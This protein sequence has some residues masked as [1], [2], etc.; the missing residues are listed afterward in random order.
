MVNQK[1]AGPRRFLAIESSSPRLSLAIGD[2]ERVLARWQSRAAWRHSEQLVEAID[3]LAARRRW[4]L[5]SF[6]GVAV[7]VGPGSFTGIRIGVTAA[8]AF[9]QYLSIP[10]LGFSSL[11]VLAAGAKATR[12]C[13]AAPAT[14]GRRFAAVFERTAQG[15]ERRETER[16]IDPLAWRATFNRWAR[17][18]PGLRLVETS[19]PAGLSPLAADLLPLAAPFLVRANARKAS[20][21]KVK[22]L[23]VQDPAPVERRRV[24]V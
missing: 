1:N 20:Y 23:Y 7:S 21:L 5:T 6:R 14:Q 22:P 3:R 18:Y 8:R 19:E 13:A 10:V 2:D 4:P 17:A 15:L 16:L 9:G 11:M 24:P 12:V